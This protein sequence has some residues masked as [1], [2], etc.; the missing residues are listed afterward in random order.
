[1]KLQTK[2]FAFKSEGSGLSEDGKY[3]VIKGYLSTFDDEDLGKDVVMPGAFADTI[4]SGRVIKILWQ[5]KWDEPL[6]VFDVVKEDDHGLWVEGKMPMSAWIVREKVAPMLEVKALDSLSIG[7]FIRSGKDYEWD[8]DVR[9]LLKIDLHE[10]SIVTFPM[11]ENAK[12][13]SKSA[14]FLAGLKISESKIEW[15]E[16]AALERVKKHLGVGS[17]GIFGDEI[18]QKMAGSFAVVDDSAPHLA[19]SYRYLITDVE[20]GELVVVPEAVKK[21]AAETY[22]ARDLDNAHAIESIY[23]KMGLDS[24][25]SSGFRVD[26]VGALSAGQLESLLKRGCRFSSETAGDIA[27]SIKKTASQKHQGNPG[28]EADIWREFASETKNIMEA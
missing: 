10:G 5:H 20:G 19:G 18:Q 9:R 3:Y 16:S 24:P 21:A 4:K 22:L 25:F 23:Q 15:D 26:D 6:G 17:S 12:L 28:G 27:G 11:N 7:Y 14:E 2:T 8:G 1:M 13:K